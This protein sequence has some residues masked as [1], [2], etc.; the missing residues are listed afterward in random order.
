MN[1]L[2]VILSRIQNNDDDMFQEQ[3]F[4]PSPDDNIKLIVSY[5][6]K[7]THKFNAICAIQP[8]LGHTTIKEILHR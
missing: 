6:H 2:R 7:H 5:E 4:L 1:P 8:I 3:Y